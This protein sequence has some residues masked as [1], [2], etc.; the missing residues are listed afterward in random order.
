MEAK[1]Y[2]YIRF[3]TPKQK[4]GDSERRQ[5]Q[6]AEAYARKHGLQL[7]DSLILRDEGLSA[8]KGHHIKKGSLGSFLESIKK[9]IIPAGS[10]LFVESLDRL[11]REGPLDAITQLTDIIRHGVTVATSM[12]EMELSR[13]TLNE[14][15]GKLQ[16]ILGIMERAHEESR[17]KSE[18]LK[19]AR[20][21]RREAVQKGEKH[22]FTQQCVA[23]VRPIDNG[24]KFEPIPERVG[25]IREIFEMKLR[26]HGPDTIAKDLNKSGVPWI[27]KNGWRNSYI[28]KILRSRAVIGEYQPHI[29]C[30]SNRKPTGDPIKDYYPRAISDDLFYQVQEQMHQNRG[31]GGRT[32]KNN[33]IFM[34]IARC[35]DCRATMHFI[36]KGKPPKGGS[37]ITCGSAQRGHNCNASYHLRYNEFEKTI[38]SY[39]KGLDVAGI[40]PNRE[41]TYT[42][43]NLLSC[44]VESLKGELR[45]I[46][47]RTANI[48]D[49]IELTS[50]KGLREEFV[51]K[52]ESR[53]AER[54]GVIRKLDGAEQEIR[55]LSHVKEEVQSQ[56]DSLNELYAVMSTSAGDELA[57]IRKRLNLQLKK[58]IDWIDV[59]PMGKPAL[60]KDTLFDHVEKILKARPDLKRAEIEKILKRRIKD[61]A[62][63]KYIIHF[64]SGS[65]RTIQP[66]TIN[67]LVLDYDH[68]SKEIRQW[69]INREGDLIMIKDIKD[70]TVPYHFDP[71]GRKILEL[72]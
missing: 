28:N 11:S 16:R 3:S 21:A 52:L 58:L 70:G 38:L 63:R 54:E 43:M 44:K 49:S 65:V 40:L 15:D 24:T 36:D 13:E 69:F 33:N 48:M 6:Y 37:Y 9:G 47:I 7:D 1:V 66:D 41:S 23:W 8:F 32:G 5:L 29:G 25:I 60:T 12:P 14:N 61:K 62:D 56:V 42:Q 39:C 45:D 46:D 68:E 10:V 30:A 18:R 19:A 50:D 59:Y 4:E 35:G 67:K 34:H 27:P 55:K 57:G 72:I 51:R 53:R 71:Y 20:K 26:G 64:K 2:S 17:T 22:V 31:K